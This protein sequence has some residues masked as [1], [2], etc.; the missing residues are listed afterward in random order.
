MHS[1]SPIHIKQHTIS[2]AAPVG[3]KLAPESKREPASGRIYH[4]T[5]SGCRKHLSAEE[6]PTLLNS[7]HSSAVP[8]SN[9][10]GMQGHESRCCWELC[11]NVGPDKYH[12]GPAYNPG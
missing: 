11:I 12:W 5:R 9:A 7:R 2:K 8:L 1:T 3:R 4:T 10:V 6:G